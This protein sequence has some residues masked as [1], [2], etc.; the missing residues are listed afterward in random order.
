MGA[1][2]GIMRRGYS[3]EKKQFVLKKLLPPYNM[4][5]RQLSREEGIASS[6]LHKWRKKYIKV[7]SMQ[8]N[9][10]IKSQKF[11][12][13]ECLQI[14][15]ETASL[16]E[17][18]LGEYCRKK[19]FYTQD[20]QTWKENIIQIMSGL[21]QTESEDKKQ[22]KKDKERIKSLEKELR[23]K[24]KALAETAA[25]LVLRKKLQALYGEGEEEA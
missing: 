12:P 13:S 14:I 17:L 16:T 25:L 9:H 23:R 6:T 2:E 3:E 10:Q 11:S 15:I 4:S 18:E 19:G 20:I 1:N 22:A 21:K 5:I 24:D 7:G 8:E